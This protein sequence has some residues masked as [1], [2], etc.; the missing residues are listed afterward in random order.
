MWYMYM[1][2][3][4][5]SLNLGNSLIAQSHKGHF[6]SL[7]GNREMQFVYIGISNSRYFVHFLRS[8][9]IFLHTDN[10]ETDTLLEQPFIIII[11]I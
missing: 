4:A 3:F 9:H 7:I 6:L 1:Y 2:C 5:P 11:I 10:I 8:D